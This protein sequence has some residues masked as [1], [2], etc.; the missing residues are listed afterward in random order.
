M[1]WLGLN[2]W[3]RLPRLLALTRRLDR[4]GSGWT[5]E[6]LLAVGVLVVAAAGLALSGQHLVALLLLLLS[7]AV[8][9]LLGE[10]ADP[11]RA[12]VW[13]LLA[14]GLGLGLACE[15][16]R[17]DGDVGRM[18]T[19]FKFYFQVWALWAVASAAALVWLLGAPRA[20]AARGA[21]ARG[22]PRAD[23]VPRAPA[24]ALASE[25]RARGPEERHGDPA[26]I[27]ERPAPAVV[28]ARRAGPA[29]L[30]FDPSG[31]ERRQG[32]AS[33][34]PAG[35]ADDP[36]IPS[37]RAARWPRSEVCRR[38]W[39]AALGLLLA[40]SLVY[41]PIASRGKAAERFDPTLAP[42]LDGM[43]YMRTAV[44][45]EEGHTFALRSD[46][47]A[48]RWLQAHVAGSPVV[49][50]AQV[51]LYRWGSRVSVYTGLPTV[52]GW[53][54]HQK[55]QRWGDQ[56]LVDQRAAD[57]RALYA[58]PDPARKLALLRRYDVAYVYVGALERAYYPPAGLA[59]F[60][61]LVGRGLERVYE[62]AAVTIYRVVG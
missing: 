49:L 9:L 59:A 45:R 60:E 4:A 51:P 54:W 52:L 58:D 17:L 34:Q 6:V 1:L 61:Q 37:P 48:I 42:T 50:E 24:P 25:A 55:Q 35:L 31:Q 7:L 20:S 26:R 5:A 36:L 3:A 28:E 16:V 19:V 38:L 21:V 56:H 46:W 53:D 33:G 12:F 22:T 57:V 10:R 43:A 32:G 14:L 15:L 13:G 11:R 30:G 29:P 39:L 47:E 40:A 44:H 41:P 23:V 2:R 27:D 62:N 18:N 8:L